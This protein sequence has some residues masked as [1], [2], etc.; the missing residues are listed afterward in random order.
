M[1]EFVDPIAVLAANLPQVVRSR[2]IFAI[3]QLSHQANK[4]FDKVNWKDDLPNDKDIN[5]EHVKKYAARW[6]AFPGMEVA[7]NKLFSEA[8]K[9]KTNNYRNKY[10][11]RFPPQEPARHFSFRPP[12]ALRFCVT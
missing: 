3:V 6:N 5:Y 11:H 2:F 4:A 7:L 12:P 10:H 1:F 9:L 8:H